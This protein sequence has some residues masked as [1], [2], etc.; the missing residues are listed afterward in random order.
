MSSKRRKEARADRCFPLVAEIEYRLGHARGQTEIGR[1]QTLNVSRKTVFF[2]PVGPVV[3]DVPI[4]LSIPW[5]VR[6]HGTV[7]L[8]LLVSGTTVSAEEEFV[9]VRIDRYE[10]RTR[11][12]SR[13]IT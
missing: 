9:G 8:T 1:G 4:E 10:F 5:P 11:A 12:R 6:L 13:Q 3:A 2:R 7:P